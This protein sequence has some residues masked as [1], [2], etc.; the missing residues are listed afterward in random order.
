MSTVFS[1]R[2]DFIKAGAL[3]SGGLA[4]GLPSLVRAQA[5]KKVEVLIDWLHQGPNCGFIVAREKGFYSEAGLDVNVSPGKGSGSTAQLIANKVAD[6]GFVDG[7]VMGNSV[8]KGMKLKAVGSIFRRNPCAVIALEESGIKDPAQLLGKRIGIPVGAAQFQQFPAF[9]KGAGID[10]KQIEV[11]NVDPAGAAAALIGGKVDAIAGFAQGWVPSIEIKGGKKTNLM[12]FAD[13]GVQVVSNGI[14]VH[15]DYLK[16]NAE[17]LKAFVPATIKG[18]LYTRKNPGEAAEIVKK[19]LATSEV[20]ISRREIELAFQ[21]WSTPKTA[22]KSLGWG[23]IDD[24]QSTVNILKE[25]GGVS[26]PLDAA[27]LFTNDFVPEGADF[28]PQQG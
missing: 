4:L 7:Y 16:A 21:T 14:V 13:R 10:A 5:S 25:Y 1:S 28:V 6:I 19:Y 26:S 11:I 2:R 9:T 27:S 18:F 8:S 15:E 12:W 17:T 20:A 23:S 3:L 24:W 22:G